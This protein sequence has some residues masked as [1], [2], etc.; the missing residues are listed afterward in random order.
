MSFEKPSS[1][2]NNAP[3][4][5]PNTFESREAEAEIEKEAASDLNDLGLNWDSLKGKMTLD[6]GAGPAIIAEI[7][8]KKGIEVVSL[9]KNPE[10]WT[11]REGVKIPDVPYVKGDAE[12]LP[13][14]DE[15]FDFVIS[16]AGPLSLFPTKEGVIQTLKEAERVLKDGGEIR[17]G[18]GNL[19]ANIFSSEELFTVEEEES[20]T[21]EQ[22][23]ERIG[24]K[25]IE[26]L[27]SINP[28]IRQELIEDPSYDYSSNTFYVLKKAMGG[29]KMRK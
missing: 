6:V 15:T 16:H 27:K 14:P 19:N 8:K 25:A 10:M 1:I 29:G 24:E 7:A 2:E 13:F 26:F 5:N 12:K 11:E 17:F 9:D 28:N 20:F 4:E 3:A 18:P 22:R 21:T 23:I